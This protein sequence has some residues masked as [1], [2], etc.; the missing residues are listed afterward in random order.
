MLDLFLLAVIG[1]IT[2]C[3]ASDGAWGAAFTMI[4]V[5]IAGLLA[6]SFF[7]VTA[8][9]LEQNIANSVE[10]QHRW[11][12]IA[13][14]GL[15]AAFVYG[16]RAATEQILPV[17]IEIHGMVFDIARWTCGLITGW[18]TMSILLTAL[19]TAPLPRKFVG[20]AP[21]PGN[22]G[23]PIGQMGPD[24]KWLGYVHL[25]TEKAFRRGANGPIFDGATFPFY[26]GDEFR[27]L[28]SFP[29]RYASRRDR[30]YG[31]AAPAAGG[32]TL[33]SGPR[34]PALAASP[35]APRF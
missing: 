27:I 5:V 34:G 8:T 2:W 23:G 11:D 32:G 6:T 31:T 22:R 25:M 7:E 20:F 21:E 12:I 9:F 17:D 14:V 16:L 30:Y 19:H 28:P 18:V 24:L 29:I 13:F 33:G 1:V 26:P 3:V 10:W 35:G 4:S 15:F